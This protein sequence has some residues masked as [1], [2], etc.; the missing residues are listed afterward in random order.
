MVSVY[1]YI[2]VADV[3][4]AAIKDYSNIHSKYTDPKIEA[5]I[6][7][8]E[9]AVNSYCGDISFSTPIP[10]SVVFVTTTAT[11]RFLHNRMVDDG[12][13]DR[14]NPKDYWKLNKDEM[15]MLDKMLEKQ[16]ANRSVWWV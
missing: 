5:N 11:L 16:R 15:D 4:N 8:A 12:A 3:E 10:D 13:M 1:G 6:T 2:T 14:E 9:R 7:L